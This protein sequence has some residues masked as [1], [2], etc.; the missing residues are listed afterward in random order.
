MKHNEDT[1]VKIPALLHLARLGFG[2]LS[3]KNASWDPETNIFTDIFMESLSRINPELSTDDIRRSLKERALI[4]KNEDLGR[5]FYQQ[6]IAPNSP[7]WMDF[8]DFDKN[9]FHIVT[10][11]PYINGDEEFRPDITLL[12][13]GLPLAFIEVKKPN[14]RDGILAE[15]ERMIR[16]LANPKFR[17]FI[18]ITQLMVFSNNMEYDGSSPEP[19]Q[20]AFYATPSYGRP[21][22]NYFR[23]ELPEELA[24]L[25]PLDPTT[26]ESILKD[27]NLQSIR[28]APEY[29]TNCDPDTPTHRLCT[30][31]FARQRLGFMLRY[32]IAYAKQEKGV[33]KQVM[34]YP[35]FFASKAIQRELDSGRRKGII[36]HTQGSG[37]TALAFY[38][39]YSLTHYFRKKNIIPKFYF[40]VDRIDLL[41]QAAREF[42]ARGLTVHTIQSREEFAN[43]IKSPQ[44]VHND[45]G[46]AEITV[47]NIQR[48]KDDADVVRRSDYNINLQRVYFLD[49]VHRSYKPKGSFLANLHQSDQEAIKIGLTGTPLL[50]AESGSRAIFGEYI[51]KYYYNASIAD[52]YT[53]RLV[54]EEIETKYRLNLEKTLEE[55]EVLKGSQDR[56]QLYSHT[57][58]VE[59]MLDYIVRDFQK[60]RI[61]HDDSTIGAMVICD[62]AAQAR[63][64]AALFQKKYAP[65][66]TPLQESR[67]ARHKEE[68]VSGLVTAEAIPQYG[69]SPNEFAVTSHALILHDEGTGAERKEKIE[70]FKEGNIDI[71]FVFNML[72]TGFDAR[73]LKKLYLGRL[74]R[75]H[76]LLQSL[77]RVNRPYKDFRYG[78]VVDFADIQ[79][80]FDITNKAYFAELQSELGDELKTYSNLFKTIDEITTEVETI[81]E[82]IWSYNMQNAEIFQQQIS[83]IQERGKMQEIVKALGQARELYNVIRLSGRQEL[84]D[85]LD[86]RQLSRLYTEASNH[87][88]LI[89]Q[90]AALESADRSG[91]I[92][93]IALEDVLFTFRKIAEEELIIADKL[94][95][96][97]RKTRETLLGNIDPGDPKF[98]SLREELER[99]FKQKNLSEISKDEMTENIDLLDDLQHR[100]QEL[101]RQNAL[102]RAKYGNDAKYVRLH[103]RLME[104]HSQTLKESKLCEAL[105]DFKQ[106]VDERIL[107]NAQI[108][109]NEAYTEK[110]LLRLAIESLKNTHQLGLDAAGLKQLNQL[111]MKEYL[112]EFH[113]SAAA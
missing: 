99:L 96:A 45:S 5:E 2:Y 3:L 113:G 50:G 49:E 75:A 28:H 101:H 37:K 57:K 7:R 51:H 93:N 43:D 33:E 62:S 87:L 85:V 84:L 15:R 39:V 35:Q 10:E 19:L 48:F 92:L 34:R 69:S 8:E 24:G 27:T 17:R 104:K 65:K 18:N 70:A 61:T 79:Q 76:N 55:I 80:E 36:W 112:D 52:G 71:L 59:P 63:K 29:Q 9:T 82:V 77:T 53:L 11:L 72:L 90:K 56:Q 13:N 26:E 97:L 41:M 108:L 68:T 106:R 103:K 100:A 67:R 54:R 16:R 111:V 58:F 86:F 105:N 81:K 1:R 94:R 38:N 6:L 110:E 12:I 20:G 64:M 83:E 31:L 91:G 42:R 89:N 98:I 14:N 32:G 109:N 25:A 88:A 107:H 95:E 60:A 22:F 21:E 47:V 78:Y 73:R 4:L 46:Q 102:L 44:A 74:I 30:S 23:E 40:I 66:P